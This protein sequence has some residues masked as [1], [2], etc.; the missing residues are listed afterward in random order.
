MTLFW[1]IHTIWSDNQ[2][3]FPNLSKSCGQSG[4]SKLEALYTQRSFFLTCPP[5]YLPS[6]SLV[7]YISLSATPEPAANFRVTG[8]T[9]ITITVTW[10]KRFNGLLE[11]LGAIL[12]FFTGLASA[13]EI[14]VSGC[15]ATLTNL[16]PFAF[17]NVTLFV[18]NRLGRSAPVSLVQQTDSNCEFFVFVLLVL[19]CLFYWF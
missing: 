13:V 7:F 12:R 11:I 9:S 1:G 4:I 3:N 5:F 10:D 6:L 18:T 17:Y 16:T 19:V 15:N 8:T 2:A 14:T